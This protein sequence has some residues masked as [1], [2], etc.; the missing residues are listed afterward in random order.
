VAQV[1]CFGI[2]GCVSVRHGDTNFPAPEGLDSFAQNKSD[3]K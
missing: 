2:S 1:A 3:K